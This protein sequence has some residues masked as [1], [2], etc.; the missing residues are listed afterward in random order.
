MVEAFRRQHYL[1]KAGYVS[2]LLIPL[3]LIL[4]RSLADGL[5]VV[6][7]LSFLAHSFIA[8]DWKWTADPVF[9]I[10][11]IAWLW[12]V[13]VVSPFAYAPVQSVAVAAPWIRF[14]LFYAAVRHWL[15]VEQKA[16]QLWSYVTLGLLALVV[17]DT[18]WQYVFHVSLSGYA[19]EVS[20]RLTGPFGQPK[21]G[22]FIAK[23]CIPPIG[24][25][26]FTGL[27]K[28]KKS[29]VIAAV[30]FLL[31]CLVTM[32][33]AGERT[34][35]CSTILAIF[36]IVGVACCG[37]RKWRIVSLS[38]VMLL[39]AVADFLVLTQPV[40]QERIGWLE[41]SLGDYPHSTYGQ[42]VMGGI[43][44]GKEH[45]ATGAGFKGFRLLCPQYADRG[46]AGFCSIHP[47]NPYVEWFSE[48]GVLG[49]MLFIALLVA[50]ASQAL[51]GMRAKT[52]EQQLLHAFA[53]AV[54]LL[55]F[56]PLLGTQSF[57]SN[58]PGILLWYSVSTGLASL[59]LLSPRQSK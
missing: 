33:L 8:K 19:T 31:A 18:I 55:N 41:S 1:W 29:L 51:R 39:C 43:E 30:G 4:S 46:L 7:G 13:L 22:I 28:R 44:I 34:A 45:L 26:L 38:L 23:L 36:L 24:V 20:H 9:K 57:F 2:L 25:L 48:T 40:V 17:T 16:T 54:V 37:E 27:V 11:V 10:G 58:W 14:I 50:M 47:H 6:A 52:Q 42:L 3:M 12:M 56:F 15:L 32:M 5:C 49:L 35:S 59:N 53:A 21:V